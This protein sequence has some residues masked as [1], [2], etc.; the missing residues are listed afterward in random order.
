LILDEATSALD[1]ESEAI[2]QQA[3]NN[4][5][6]SRERTVVVIAH[7]LSTIRNADRIALIAEGKVAECG[8]H[9]EL[10]NKPHGR[11]KRLFESSKRRSTVESVG[12]RTGGSH[13]ISKIEEEEKEEEID[14][15]E[16]IAEEEKKAF[17]VARARQMARPDATFLLFGALG[18]VI[19]G[20]VFPTWGI[21][22]RFVPRLIS[23]CHRRMF[24]LDQQSNTFWCN[25]QTIT[26][27]FTP[28]FPCQDGAAPPLA[29]PTPYA[30]CDAYWTGT[31]DSMR[32]RSF[33]VAGY[34]ACL[35]V[36]CLLGNAVMFYGF[37]RA[38][39]S[40]NKRIRDSSFLALLRQEVAFFDKRSVGAITS[41][42]QDDAARVHAFSGEPIRT[43]ISALG[44][45]AIGVVISLFVSVSDVFVSMVFS[46]HTLM[47]FTLE[48]CVY[49]DRV[50]RSVHVAT[51]FGNDCV[52]S[53]HGL[54]YEYSDE[55]NAWY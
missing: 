14:W 54:R 3:I 55:A 5:M 26:L 39:E 41:Q 37:G 32:Q 45:V 36:A 8:S 12:L 7:R 35:V 16:K 25:S 29:P 19:C 13:Q 27:L 20:G 23:C 2:V 43:V 28:V 48:N 53:D 40:L 4:L 18:A 1:N 38:S 30:T 42:L 34:W 6:Q 15:E 44:S 46:L 49:T 31:A 9:D 10:I 22:F 33:T 47:R 17:S 11:Y 52:Y 24:A 21:L 50:L 51:I